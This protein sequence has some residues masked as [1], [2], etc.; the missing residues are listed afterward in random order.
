MYTLHH[1]LTEERRLRLSDLQNAAD[2]RGERVLR[3]AD[4]LRGWRMRT[5]DAWRSAAEEPLRGERF[6]PPVPSG[7]RAFDLWRALV[8][9]EWDLVREIFGD[10]LTAEVEASRELWTSAAEVPETDP[11]LSGAWGT[12]VTLDR[13]RASEDLDLL[14]LV[15]L[16]CAEPR[17]ILG[18]SSAYMDGLCTALERSSTLVDRVRSLGEVRVP[19]PV[20]PAVVARDDAWAG[21]GRA[22]E[23]G[24]VAVVATGSRED[25]LVQ[26]WLLEQ[27]HKDN[28]PRF[29]GWRVAVAGRDQGAGYLVLPDGGRFVLEYADTSLGELEARCPDPVTRLELPPVQSS[30][31]LADALALRPS[32]FDV[33]ERDYTLRQ[34]TAAWARLHPPQPVRAQDLRLDILGSGRRRWP[35]HR[36]SVR[37]ALRGDTAALARTWPRLGD[38]E[39]E[40]FGSTEAWISL[41]VV[42]LRLTEM[43]G[44]QA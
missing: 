14:G 37:A 13:L 22:F 29:E 44:T 30:D 28:V 6:L 21:L 18:I 19:G 10:D 35:A 34:L 12:R 1:P 33:D 36:G 27:R 9:E 4:R 3:R 8:V 38:E 31:L 42:D 24:A 26:G 23:D 39:R 20:P 15:G 25:A 2:A 41:L 40:L 5:W 16:M 32:V 11:E 43:L 17:S 7:L